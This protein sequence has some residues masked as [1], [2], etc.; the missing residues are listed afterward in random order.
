MKGLH[1][2]WEEIYNT[3]IQVPV[4]MKQGRCLGGIAISGER[5]PLN[6]ILARSQDVI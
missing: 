2:S 1:L 6:D 5:S 4:R 3:I